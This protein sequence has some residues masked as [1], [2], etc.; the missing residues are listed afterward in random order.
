VENPNSVAQLARWLGVPSLDKKAL[1]DLLAEAT[2]ARREVLDL[3]RQIALSAPKKYTVAIEQAHDGRLRNMLQY[4]G[5]GRTHR[6]SGR[7]LQPQNLRRGF[8]DSEAIE[9]AWRAIE[10][11]E[12]LDRP[13]DTLADLVRSIIVPRRGAFLGVA[14]YSSIEVVMLHWAAGDTSMLQDLR[15]GLDPY[16]RFA[17]QHWAIPVDRVTKEQRTFSKPIVLGCGYG[18]GADTLVEYAKGMGVVMSAEQANEAVNTYRRENGP[19]RRLW[20]GLEDA[21]RS[22]IKSPDKT[23]RYGHVR[24]TKA[25]RATMMALPS[26]RSI[27]YWDARIDEDDR[28]R[29]MGVDQYT[30]HW[31]DLSTWGGKLVENFVQSISRDVLVH[32]LKNAVANGLDVILHVHDEIVID[33]GVDDNLATLCKGM[34][35]PAWCADA[36]ITAAVFSCP[37]YRKD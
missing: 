35:A 12:P 6:W 14:D 10:A 3:R 11:G 27:T 30:G 32:G 33:N 21:M 26:G 1:P 13:F 17:N 18:L 7:G 25:G 16:K 28:L 2:G 36:P 8:K 19:V 4:S 31:K 22:A 37:R 9:A 29:Y 5:A 20:Y 23:Y 34:S 24:F 15:N